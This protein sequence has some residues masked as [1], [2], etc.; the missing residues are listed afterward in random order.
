MVKGVFMSFSSSVTIESC[1]EIIIFMVPPGKV[2]MCKQN[3]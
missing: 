3:V 1:T 2:Q